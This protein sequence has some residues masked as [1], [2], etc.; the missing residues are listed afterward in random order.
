MRWKD[1]RQYTTRCQAVDKMTTDD[2]IRDSRWQNGG[3]MTN[4]NITDDKMTDSRWL[5]G[6]H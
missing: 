3:E 4:D 6:R 2:K 1:D 5:D